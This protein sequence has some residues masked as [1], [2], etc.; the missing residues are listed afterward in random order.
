[1]PARKQFESQLA[2][3]K[4]IL[5]QRIQK[6]IL[7]CVDQTLSRQRGHKIYLN[8]CWQNPSNISEDTK[9]V[10]SPLPCQRGNNMN[11]NMRWKSP[12]YANEYSKC[13]W[14]CVDQ[15][16]P[17]LV[18]TQNAYKL[19]W[20]NPNHASKKCISTCVDQTPSKPAT[21]LDSSQNPSH[22]R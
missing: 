7:T 10:L 6:C 8:F 3:K 4:P 5:R 9:Y 2:L 22:A 14:P 15:T 20:P 21:T 13:I 16:Q 11:L 19:C 17:M 1:M 12:S 18:S